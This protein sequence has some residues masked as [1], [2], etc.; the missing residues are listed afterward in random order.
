MSYSLAIQFADEWEHR[1][2]EFRKTHRKAISKRLMLMIRADV[3]NSGVLPTG[4]WNSRDIAEK[5]CEILSERLENDPEVKLNDVF[6]KLDK[7]R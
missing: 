7:K 1:V 5:A 6:N 2:R 4:M 3:E